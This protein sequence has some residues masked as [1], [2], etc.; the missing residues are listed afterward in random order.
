VIIRRSVIGMLLGLLALVTTASSIGFAQQPA[1]VG[2]PAPRFYLLDL[3]GEEF[4]LREW[5]APQGQQLRS[6]LKRERHAVVLSFFATWCVPCREE[7]PDLQEL[8]RRYE[9]QPVLWKIVDVMDKPDSVSAFLERLNVTLPTLLDRHGKVAEK[10]C[11]ES[12]SVPTAVVIDKDG[13]V[14]Y[15]A[16]GY[17]EQTMVDIQ[18]TL[19]QIVG[20]PNQDSAREE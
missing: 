12:V 19:D 2:E 1:S 18:R 3:D 20:P 10:Y 15:L 17:N 4:Y 16:S 11:G 9:G 7:L 5:S 6:Y 14:R 8:S 13:V